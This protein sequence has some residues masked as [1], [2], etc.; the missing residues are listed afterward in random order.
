ML[1]VVSVDWYKREQRRIGRRGS[2]TNIFPVDKFTIS[3]LGVSQIS[4]IPTFFK[5]LSIGTSTL[6]PFPSSVKSIF[7]K[8][9]KVCNISGIPR[10]KLSPGI[11]LLPFQT[12][13]CKGGPWEYYVHVTNVE[14]LRTS[15]VEE[16]TD[17]KNW[18][19][20]N[21]RFWVLWISR[22]VAQSPHQQSW[23]N[24]EQMY[25]ETRR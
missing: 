10:K 15:I 21:L 18:R 2:L 4:K 9:L 17:S 20:V 8:S 22:L 19:G 14:L 12:L 6:I 11:F 13:N 7:G 5:F 23:Q 25:A 24:W 16:Q 1:Q 3:T